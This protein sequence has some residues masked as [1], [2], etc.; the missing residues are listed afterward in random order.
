MKEENSE[1]DG[2]MESQ[3]FYW[4]WYKY[5]INDCTFVTGLKWDLFYWK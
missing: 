3:A 4:W 1:K 5:Q 2:E